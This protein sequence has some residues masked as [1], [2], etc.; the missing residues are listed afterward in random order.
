[1]L[2]MWIQRTFQ[3]KLSGVKKKE[4]DDTKVNILSKQPEFEV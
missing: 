3:N 2:W 4:K 1:M